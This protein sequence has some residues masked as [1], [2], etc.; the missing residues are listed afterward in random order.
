MFSPRKNIAAAQSPLGQDVRRAASNEQARP[1]PY[2]F[3]CPWIG[4]T[5]ISD[6]FDKKVVAV[7]S[8]GG[9][10]KARDGANYF[11]SAAFLIG[12]GPFDGLAGI[13][14]NGNPVYTSTTIVSIV[15]ITRVTT[16]ATVETRVAHGLTTGDEIVITGA[17]QPEYNG[18]QTITVVDATHFTFA[19]TGTP[20]TPATGTIT[21]RVQLD[22]VLRDDDHPDGVD[23]TIPDYGVISFHW[24]TETQLPDE[25]LRTASGLEFPAWRGF[26]F[27]VLKQL[28]LGFN[29]TNFQ[30]LE[31]KMLKYPRFDWLPD[32]NIEGDAN[33]VAVIVDLLTAPRV[34]VAPTPALN[35]KFTNRELGFKEDLARWRDAAARN[36]LI[37]GGASVPASRLDTE[38]S[39]ETSDWL[40]GKSLGISSAETRSQELRQLLQRALEHFDGY[41]GPSADGTVAIRKLD[42]I[43]DPVEITDADL[44]A[45]PEL[46][47]DDWNGEPVDVDRAWI[48]RPELAQ[49][50]AEIAGLANA[51]PNI[52]GRL[53]L[54]LKWTL[55]DALPPGAAFTLDHSARDLSDLVFRVTERTLPDPA[56]AEFIISFET[57]RTQFNDDTELEHAAVTGHAFSKAEAEVSAPAV[58]VR[59][60]ELPAGLS[61]DFDVTLAPLVARTAPTDVGF[62]IYQKKDYGDA[63][64]SY[65]L[66]ATATRF[67]KHGS[68]AADYGTDTD[69]I[70]LTLGLI[71][72]LDGVDTVLDDQTDFDALADALLIF[73][74]AEVLS[75][76]GITLL[77]SGLYKVFA[78]RERFGSARQAHTAG[79]EVFV[80][81]K[82]E[83]LRINHPSFKV[84]NTITVKLAPQNNAG[85]TDLGDVA[86]VSLALTG[87]LFTEPKLANLSVNGDLVA[88]TYETGD[89]IVIDWSLVLAE[90][91]F[92]LPDRYTVRTRLD[93]L[94]E[95]DFPP[96]VE[97]YET[98]DGLELLGTEH[99]EGNTFMIL[100]ADLITLLGGETDF[101][102]FARREVETPEGLILS[103]QQFLLVTKI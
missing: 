101:I 58:A 37:G 76:A 3:G 98:I 23:I 16:V 73:V 26:G 6:A 52:T 12:H 69:T 89:D 48:T 15:K 79:A 34:A 64:D 96:T 5:W 57:D 4:A 55:F 51:L 103:A 54:R 62:A 61:Q 40:I 17:L 30:N 32:A 85:E 56:R 88:P 24:G 81:R 82:S 75:I 70:D 60:L 44:L 21:F 50:L 86:P 67:A 39:A 71:V 19:V 2:L 27:G 14:L 66:R 91:T 45:R 7:S 65:E 13:R 92:L 29:Q 11:A 53:Q 22:P 74:G 100:N 94:R 38:S 63:P 49:R 95:I 72:Q 99:V 36:I 31:V 80:I 8:G 10:T 84:G 43:G 33:P 46:N 78:I 35:F 59:L 1:V 77:A 20:V 25:Y 93:F 87:R 41:F 28:F 83:L 97:L 68:L 102:I 42:D 18:G 47:P 9:K 90:G